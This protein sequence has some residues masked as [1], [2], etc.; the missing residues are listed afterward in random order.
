MHVFGV[1][2]WTG[3]TDALLSSLLILTQA[4]VLGQ[5][6]DRI[7]NPVAVTEDSKAASAG[8]NQ[9]SYQA[10]AAAKPMQSNPHTNPMSSAVPSQLDGAVFPIKSLNPYQNKWTIKARVVNKSDVR[11]WSNAKG[12]GKLFSVTLLDDSGEIKA[13]GFNDSVDKL[14]PLLEE[15]KV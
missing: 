3:L 13:T 10:P 6:P 14:Y 9:S 2:D 12:E 4:D 11:T 1:C 7:G 8:G 15:D 5:A